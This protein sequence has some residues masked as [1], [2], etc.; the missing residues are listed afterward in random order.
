MDI[1]ARRRSQPAV[2]SR[3]EEK[4]A[5]EVRNSSGGRGDDAHRPIWV[6]DEVEGGPRLPGA[7]GRPAAR[8]AEVDEALARA[9]EEERLRQGSEVEVHGG[10]LGGHVRID[11]RL[12]TLLVL[13]VCGERRDN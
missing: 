4:L 7:A 9:R 10:C 3:E 1:I 2:A 5:T 11:T 8:Q 6:D 13:N 12:R